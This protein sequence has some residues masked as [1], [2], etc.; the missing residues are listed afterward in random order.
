M[1]RKLYAEKGNIKDLVLE[2]YVES[3]LKRIKKH[4]INKVIIL[5][6]IYVILILSSIILLFI[7]Y[8]IY[9]NL[10]SIFNYSV[11]TED[12]I[13]KSD[14][15]KE[16]SANITTSRFRGEHF[17]KM[18][19]KSSPPNTYYPSCFLPS[20]LKADV[21]DFNLLEYIIYNQYTVLDYQVKHTNEYIEGLTNILKQYQS[22]ADRIT[23]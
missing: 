5:L 1:S 15:F 21:K 22:I 3:N 10:D 2:Y 7:L 20:H 14:C 17:V 9:S 12:I 6:L 19:Y 23:S 18:F 13:S 8:T 16:Q 11:L 4:D